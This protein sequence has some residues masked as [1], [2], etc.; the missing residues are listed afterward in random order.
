V[1]NSD[2]IESGLADWPPAGAMMVQIGT[3]RFDAL[4]SDVYGMEN[5]CMSGI[6]MF[7]V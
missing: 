1:F 7:I 6:A 2:E 3:T 5:N 4:F